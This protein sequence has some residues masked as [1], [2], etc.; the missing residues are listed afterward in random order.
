MG[1][2][3]EKR[4]MRN[5]LAPLVQIGQV[6]MSRKPT[7]GDVARICQT[8]EILGPE[9]PRP[10]EAR[11]KFDIVNMDYGRDFLQ[12][13]KRYQIVLVHSVFHANDNFM[14]GMREY[15]EEKRLPWL[16]SR[17]HTLDKWRERLVGTRAGHIL[18]FE[19]VPMSLNG[20]QLGD[21]NGYAIERRDARVTY[22][23]KGK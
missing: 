6:G 4:V 20:W 1:R 3:S 8:I 9:W 16:V 15:W 5:T 22:Y 18:V 7:V 17:F 23:V 11:F 12:E 19:S 2:I 13:S 10:P 14:G 21:L